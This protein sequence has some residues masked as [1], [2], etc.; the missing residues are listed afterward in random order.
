M[1]VR[2]VSTMAMPPAR[3]AS[4]R[5]CGGLVMRAAAARPFRHRARAVERQEAGG[6]RVVRREVGHGHGEDAPARGA[7]GVEVEMT[8]PCRVSRTRTRT[9]SAPRTAM[10]SSRAV[11]GRGPSG[12]S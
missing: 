10:V 3:S 8:G 6:R 12:V 7:F 4:I 9:G 2:P 5:F 11:K 1:G